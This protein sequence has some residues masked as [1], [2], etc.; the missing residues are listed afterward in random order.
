MKFSF[1]LKSAAANNTWEA[2]RRESTRMACIALAMERQGHDVQI[3][4]ASP[5]FMDCPNW[6]FFKHL[7]GAS[8]GGFTVYPAETLR[9]GQSGVDIAFRCSVGT[10]FDQS[11]IGQCRLLVAHEYAKEVENEPKL[12]PVPFMIHNE[13]IQVL[14]EDGLFDAFIDNDLDTIRNHFREGSVRHDK[15][16]GFIGGDWPSRKSLCDNHPE[17]VDVAFYDHVGT[18]RMEA[19]EHC[20]WLMRFSA[21]LAMSGSTPKTNLPSLLA[22]LGIPIVMEPIT[23]FDTPPFDDTNTILMQLDAAGR[24]DWS[25]VL[26]VLSNPDAVASRQAKATNDYIGSWSPAGH[27]RLISERLNP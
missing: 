21:A 19:A 20:R 25:R 17:W 12:L 22:M 6:Q 11:Y 8:N 1:Y 15:L 24:P 9:R 13:V 16:V 10:K 7:H 14:A 27:A 5:Q 4:D 26:R 3:A 2:Q 18:R 23:V